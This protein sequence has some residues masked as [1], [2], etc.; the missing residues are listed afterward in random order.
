MQL[1]AVFKRWLSSDILCHC[2]VFAKLA[3]SL[4]SS[5]VEVT[6]YLCGVLL[7]ASLELCE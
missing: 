4:R 7:I 6:L 1:A 3:S 2:C 5:V